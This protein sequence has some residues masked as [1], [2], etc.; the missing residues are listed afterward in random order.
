MIEG[1]VAAL[2]AF[3]Q[4]YG[5][6]AILVLMAAESA[7]LPVPSEP[8][9]IFG[10]YLV[11][12]NSLSFTAVVVAGTLGNLLGSLAA[13]WFGERSEEAIYARY[14]NT[15]LVGH[16]LKIAERWFAKYGEP[17]VFFAR[18]LPVVRTFISLPAGIA[19]MSFVRFLAYTIVGSV[20]WNAA[21][22]YL[23][24]L[25]GPHWKE[26]LALAHEWT[27]V[28]LGVAV[29]GVALAIWWGRR[30]GLFRHAEG[31]PEDT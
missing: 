1:F 13:Y 21:L 31:E 6:W 24:F 28:A 16:K 17:A 18:L 22:T 5:F 19:H 29:I 27:Y 14:S 25:A 9:M 23:G 10:G 26:T 3:V 15:P 8:V 20:M 7:C 11:Y 4:G 12:N 30:K 2:L